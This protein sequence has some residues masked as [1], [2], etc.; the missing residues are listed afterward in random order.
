MD[1]RG[2]TSPWRGPHEPVETSP[3]TLGGAGLQ[4][5]TRA[6]ADRVVVR[7]YGGLRGDP[8]PLHGRGWRPPPRLAPGGRGKATWSFTLCSERAVS[9]A[10]VTTSEPLEPRME[11]SVE[12]PCGFG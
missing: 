7:R 6:P 1:V 3:P 9:L 2:Q 5:S 11:T 10:L 12:D 4:A 8:W